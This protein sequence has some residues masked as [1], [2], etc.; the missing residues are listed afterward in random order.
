ME[1]QLE[2]QHGGDIYSYD[3]VLDFSI[4]INPFGPSQEVQQAVHRAVSEIA[5]YPDVHCRELL[6][7]LSVAK[8]IEQR[9]CICGNGAAELI[10][11]LVQAEKPK[12]ALLT[13]P[14]FGEY[15][16]AL[17]S[18]GCTIEYVYLKREEQFDVTEEILERLDETTDILFLCSPSNPAGRLI[19]ERLLKQILDTCERLHIRVVF[20]VCFAEFSSAA[21]RI[22]E[23]VRKEA[24]RCVF[25]LEAF[26]KTYG[27]PGLRLGYGISRDERLLAKMRACMQPWNVSVLAQAA[28]VAALS[29]AEKKRTEQMRKYVAQERSF[30]EKE[31]KKM[32]IVYIPSAANYILLSS[33]FD[34]FALLKEKGILIRD[35]R[36]YVG[37]EQ[38]DYRIAVKLHEENKKLIEAVSQ[39][40][41]QKAK[42]QQKGV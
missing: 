8:R 27:I 2:Y 36:N 42:E 31:L 29:A 38:G 10:F 7:V 19:E 34:L 20:D 11:S 1:E 25:W 9:Y 35:C 23:V 5:R 26:T 17:Q 14:S 30:I 33:P 22:A 3:K 41:R 37:L 12:K 40:Y 16:R 13:V 28:G 39:I 15:E 21:G 32:G 4:N 18:A 6:Q 24:Y